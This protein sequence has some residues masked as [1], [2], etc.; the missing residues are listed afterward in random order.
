MITDTVV[1]PVKNWDEY[2]DSIYEPIYGNVVTKGGEGSGNFGHEGRPGEVGGSAPGNGFNPY[3]FS[4]SPDKQYHGGMDHGQKEMHLYGKM[5]TAKVYLTSA[6]R[7]SLKRYKEGD[8]EVNAYS[9]NS[10]LRRASNPG[11][12]GF[13]NYDYTKLTPEQKMEVD[14]IIDNMD[15]VFANDSTALADDLLAYRGVNPGKFLDSLKPGAIIHEPGFMSTTLDKTWA[16]HFG[17]HGGVI[18][19]RIPKGTHAIYLDALKQMYQA[20]MLLNRGYALRID[21]IDEIK[22]GDTIFITA[23]LVRP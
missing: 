21:S 6:Q 16:E 17:N 9:V 10:K 22:Y 2:L 23:S 7:A 8:Y 18:K 20:E 3:V 4:R 11:S 19:I 13:M 14:S 12:S 15:V 1:K 5:H